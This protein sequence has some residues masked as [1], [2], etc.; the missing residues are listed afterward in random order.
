MPKAERKAYL[1][2]LDPEVMLALALAAAANKRS[3]NAEIA[4]R[5]ELSLNSYQR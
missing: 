2:R 3:I 5:L 1:L 4:H